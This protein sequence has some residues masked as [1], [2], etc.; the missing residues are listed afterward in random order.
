METIRSYIDSM[1]SVFEETD[2]VS[3]LREDITASMEDKYYELKAEGKSE[4][5]AIGTVIAEFGNIDELAQE[6]G[7]KRKDKQCNTKPQKSIPT[8][9]EAETRNFLSD[10]K[11]NALFIALGVFLCIAAPGLMIATAAMPVVSVENNGFAIEMAYSLSD[12][13]MALAFTL[14]FA[15]IAAAVALFIIS[16]MRSAKYNYLEKEYELDQ[17]TEN[18]VRQ[19]RERFM[20]KYRAFIAIGVVLCVVSPLA[21]IVPAF[22]IPTY[23]SYIGVCVGLMLLI[24]AAGVFL[25]VYGG[26]ISSSYKF[27]LQEED[28]EVSKKRASEEKGTKR[29]LAVFWAAVPVIYLIVSFA[30]G[31]WHMTWLIWPIAGVVDAVIVNLK[32]NKGKE[33]A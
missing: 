18:A 29:F 19:D 12:R 16:G 7:I 33:P 6:L 32:A 26:Y 30:T 9:P 11:K 22:A 21:V 3:K 23:M 10:K 2:A 1:F 8:L 5:E 28:Y 24:V 25:L 17:M 20:P 4:N 15:L 27:I 14:L 31:A 13:N